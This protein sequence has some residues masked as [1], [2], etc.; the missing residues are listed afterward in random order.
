MSAT[1]SNPADGNPTVGIDAREYD[2][3][4]DLTTAS[5]DVILYDRDVETA[6]IQSDVA[7]DLENHR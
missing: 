1:S 5:G 6:W 3:Y 2:R 4:A 7:I